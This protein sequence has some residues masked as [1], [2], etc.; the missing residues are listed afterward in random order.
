MPTFW[1]IWVTG[2]CG[3]NK[4]SSSLKNAHL[5][6]LGSLALR[7]NGSTSDS[8]SEGDVITSSQGP[9][10]QFSLGVIKCSIPPLSY[11][12]HIHWCLSPVYIAQR[13][14]IDP[15]QDKARQSIAGHTH[16]IQS[17]FH[18]YEKSISIHLLMDVCGQWDIGFV[19]QQ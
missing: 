4:V 7:C 13:H 3:E 1:T 18:N 16:N 9:I 5:W 10:T 11:S 6:T 17:L 15:G 2:I 19:V 12:P 14:G 8:R